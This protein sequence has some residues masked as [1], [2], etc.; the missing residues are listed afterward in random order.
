VAATALYK[1]E[2]YGFCSADCKTAFLEDPEAYLPP[3]F[4]RPAPE[5]RVLDLEGEEFASSALEGRWVLLDFWAT[6]C[7]PCV[8]DLPR[9][10]RLHES[11]EAEGVTVVSVSI[12]EGDDAARKVSRMIK[13]RDATHPVFVDTEDNPAWAAYRVKVVPAQFLI[14]NEGRIV[15]QWSGK[16]DLGKVEQEIRRRL[17]EAQPVE[18]EQTGGR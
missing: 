9:L 16:V 14:D 6:W 12:D 17:G 18:Q 13:K 1:G 3:V 7:Q 8:K 11:L 2:T 4:P 10:S 15:A 5:F